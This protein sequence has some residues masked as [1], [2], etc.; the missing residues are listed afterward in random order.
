MT[1]QIRLACQYCDTAECDGVTEIP[2]DWSDVQEV[3][4]IAA[5]CE[6]IAPD[7]QTRS[8]LEWYTH[9]GVCPACRKIYG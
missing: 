2:P 7:D 6:P 9:L 4:S 8:P 3:Q 5:S 1:Q